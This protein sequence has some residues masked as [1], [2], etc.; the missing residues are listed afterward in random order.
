MKYSALLLVTAGLA[1]AQ[2]SVVTVVLPQFD[3]QAIDASVIAAAPTATTYRLNCPPGADSSDCGMPDEFEFVYGPSTFA[4]TMSLDL[5]KD[6]ADCVGTMSKEGLSTVA[7]DTLTDLTSFMLPIT[8]TAGLDKL[9]ASTGAGTAPEAPARTTTTGGTTET[10][11]STG[12]T[13]STV[14]TSSTQTGG[15]PPQITQNAVLVGAAA[16]VGGAMLM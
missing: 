10:A 14:A 15:V 1:A 12:T 9:A 2:L 16:L 5:P 6:T 8:I 13:G 7:R 11:G 4:Y 3:Q